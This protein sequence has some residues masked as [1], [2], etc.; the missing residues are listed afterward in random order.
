MTKQLFTETTKQQKSIDLGKG[1]YMQIATK[2]VPMAIR[3][4]E[5]LSK[6]AVGKCCNFYKSS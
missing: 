2:S 4:A 3:Q 6:K 1:N 5:N